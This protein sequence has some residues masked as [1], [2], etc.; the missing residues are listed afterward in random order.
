M[1]FFSRSNSS[2]AASLRRPFRSSR[3]PHRPSFASLV[4]LLVLL[5]ISPLRAQE[6]DFFDIV[7][8]NHDGNIDRTEFGA[9]IQIF[10]AELKHI[11]LPSP[12]SWST[13]MQP[14]WQSGEGYWKAFSSSVMMILATEIGDKTFFIA[15]IL[16]MK[17]ARSAVFAG[18]MAALVAMTVLSTLMGLILPK[19]LDRRYTH[20]LSGIL[21]LYFGI[22]LL[23]DARQMQSGKVSEELEEVEEELLHSHKKKKRGEDEDDVEAAT[24]TLRRSSSLL[25]TP[26]VIFLALT[27]TFVAEWGDRSQIATIAL[28]SAK[29][30][31]GVTVGAIVGHCICTASACVGGRMLAANIQEKTV[32]QCGGAIF[33]LFAL[34]SLFFE[35]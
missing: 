7:D 22:K 11:S 6:T 26:S 4:L 29:N 33:L 16:S 14:F 34:H 9:G 32:S 2:H 25:S 17:H 20:G 8:A 31:V 19:F 23:L 30:P 18:A 1:E 27:L 12:R 24:P 35:T 3:W 21:F 5:W 10:Q 15:A 13:M 28:A